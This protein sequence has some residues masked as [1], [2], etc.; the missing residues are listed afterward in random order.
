MNMNTKTK[1]NEEIMKMSRVKKEED[2]DVLTFFNV[3]KNKRI[4]RKFARAL[5]T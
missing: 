2:V 5:L 3:F 1:M 4:S